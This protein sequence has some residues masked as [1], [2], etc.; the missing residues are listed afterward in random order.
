MFCPRELQREILPFVHPWQILLPVANV[1][2]HADRLD[3]PLHHPAR[4]EVC[5][6]WLLR[7]TNTGTL[8]VQ[9]LVLSG[10]E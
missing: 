3:P 10:F 6:C 7:A 5:E 4:V 1:V 9:K 8:V 2:R